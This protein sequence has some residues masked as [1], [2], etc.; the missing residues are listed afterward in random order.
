MLSHAIKASQIVQ[1][2]TSAWRGSPPVTVVRATTDLPISTPEDVRGMWLRGEAWIVANTQPLSKV[3]GTTAHEAIGHG[4]M[5]ST[6]GKHWRGFMHDIQSGLRGGDQRLQYFREHVR[7]VYVDDAG[8]CNLSPVSESDEIT[9]ALVEHRFN[10]ESG[11]LSI[12]SPLRKIMRAAA[13]RFSREALYCDRPVDFEQ[14]EGAILTAEHRLRHGG[15]FFGIGFRLRRWYA[16]G[17]KPWNPNAPPMS[18]D[19]SNRLL[20]AE[21]DRLRWWRDL[22]FGFDGMVLIAC[23]ILFPLC[24][25]LVIYG[26]LSPFFR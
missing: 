20:K 15:S 4:A 1:R 2:L 12:G 22:K 26:F 8:T 25:L 10:G 5:R 7:T 16:P 21:S 23:L 14:L 24:V 6:F 17:M 19:E 3:A 18:I 9:A 13:G 11:R